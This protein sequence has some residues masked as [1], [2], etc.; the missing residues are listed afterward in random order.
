MK[1]IYFLSLVLIFPA[2]ASAQLFNG[3]WVGSPVSQQI[4]NYQSK[5]FNDSYLTL[6]IIENN[7][8]CAGSTEKK[9]KSGITIKSAFAGRLDENRKHLEGKEIYEIESPDSHKFYYLACTYELKYKVRNGVEFL[10]GTMSINET[11]NNYPSASFD[12]NGQ[13]AV[14][15]SKPVLYT[16]KLKRSE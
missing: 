11:E 13:I 12:R 8:S 3:K 16:V 4:N 9:L 10:E 5:G 7:D 1:I 6:N 2:A 15:E 14:P